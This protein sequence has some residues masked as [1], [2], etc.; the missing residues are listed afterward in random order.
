MPS[1]FSPALESRQELADAVRQADRILMP[2]LQEHSQTAKALWD[3]GQDQRHR[4]ILTLAVTDPWGYAA[5]DF[6]S[7]ELTNQE[8]LHRRFNDLIGEM[9]VPRRKEEPRQRIEIRDAFITADQLE[10]LRLQLGHI[11]D[12]QNASLRLHNQLRFLAQRPERYLFT[13]FAVE[14]NQPFADAVREVIRGCG[15][16]MRDDPW[17]IKR[18]GVREALI[19]L[20]E[21][22]RRD[23]Q[24]VPSFAVC[25]L[26][27]DRTA[28]HLLEL[29]NDAPEVGDDGLEGVGFSARGV[30]PHVGSLKIYLTHPNDLRAA[31]RTNRDHPF[32]RDLRNDNCDFLS[33]DD[34]GDA[35]RRA[36]PELL[37][38]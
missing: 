10:Q 17:L 13:D 19:R 20:V 31:F 28:I 9:I 18:E 32:F 38:A 11:P 14:V 29:S 5:G 2:M 1:Q 30:V 37:G 35:F 4:D 36:F 15:F 3:V 12:I 8:H 16:Q 23:G 6:A 24:P 25:F 33:P 21:K 34:H 7:D 26:L 22:H 27:Q